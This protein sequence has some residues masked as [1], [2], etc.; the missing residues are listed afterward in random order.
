MNLE[1]SF[2]AAGANMQAMVD[3]F[4]ILL[5][6]LLIAV[7]VFAI[8]WF[9]ARLLKRAIRRVTRRHRQARNLGLVLGRLSQGAMVLLGLFIALSIMIPTFQPGDLVQLLGISGVAVGFAFRD[10]L[11]NFLAGILIL[12]TEPFQIND[13]IVFKNFEGTVEEIQ[14][15][16]TT[17]RTYDG[18]R[19][20]IPNAE[21]FTNS[22]TVNTAFE[23]RRLE[24]DIGIGYG[25]DVQQAKQLILDT[26]NNMDEVL[27]EPPPDALVV[28]LAES[29]I[30]IRLRWWIK[31]PRRADSLDS[32]DRVL[33]AV[34]QTLVAHGIDLPFPTQQILFHDQTEETDGDR[35]RQREGWPPGDGEVPKPR[36][37]GGSL[38]QLVLMRQHNQT[39]GDARDSRHE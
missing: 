17:I 32:R 28:D 3:S 25:D 1:E 12:L 34:A 13:Q 30:N 2:Q 36:S 38:K 22:V 16:A 15:R 21:L 29:T 24:Y 4:I 31:P 35:S 6:N 37:I 11:Q 5:P 7:I 23:N 26:L 8:F 9:G 39:N 27:A 10:I 33:T 19:V 18:R 20:V 14:T